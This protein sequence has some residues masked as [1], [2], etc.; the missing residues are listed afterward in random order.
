MAEERGLAVDMDGYKGLMEEHEEKSRGQAVA[1]QVAL[2][3]SG[4]LPETDDRPKWF[5]SEC[6]ATVLGWIADNAFTKGGVLF[7][8]KEAGL[9]LDQ[10]CFYAEA[11]GQVGDQGTIRSRTGTFAV[12]Q[13][14]KVGNSI[15][16][17]GQVTQGMMEVGQAAQ[18]QVDP[19]REFTRKNH[20]ATHLLHWALHKVLGEHVEQRGSK[21]KPDEFTF[22]FSHTGPLT[23]TEKADV[24]RLVNE[25]I[26]QDLPVQWRELAIADA[27]K[28]SGVKAFFGDK[29]GDVVRVVEIGDGFSREFCGGTHLDHTGQA[30]FFKIVGEEAVGKGVR[31]LTAVTAREAV[32]TVQKQDA[33]LADLTGRFR[34][35]PEELPARIE[36]LQDEIKKLQQQLKKGT[37]T[38][39]QGAADKLLAGAAEVQ[40]AKVI[41]GEV[42]AGPEE[43][44]RQQVDRLRQKA[45]S[46][47]VL[48]GWA[49]DGKVQLI[50]AVTDDLVKKGVHAGKL[51]GQVAKVVGGGG[52]GKPTMAQAGGKEPAKLPEALELAKK[53][54]REQLAR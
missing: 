27:K 40:G 51:I 25:R 52:G 11:G 2:N 49:D 53:L 29:Y 9:L 33:I 36:S 4:S 45:A 54:A 34:C 32:A 13:T 28:L 18:L 7:P 37:A 35:K 38:D 10:T 41:V 48:L 46:A 22:D 42:P 43:Q 47:V 1:Q 39:L 6:E 12:S 21:V 5:G 30:G 17:V 3:V 26:Y 31:R 50:A 8:G 23:E 14:T 15:V 19:K 20:T 16:H 24:E 44:I